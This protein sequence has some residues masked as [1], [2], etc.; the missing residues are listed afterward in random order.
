MTGQSIVSG[1]I[2]AYAGGT[3]QA[4]FLPQGGGSPTV[5]QNATSISSSGTFSF[6]CW[7]NTNAL[8]FPSLTN[9]QIQVGEHTYYGTS[10]QV[11][12]STEDISTAFA[13]APVPNQSIGGVAITN[14]P[15][16]SGKVLTS[17]STT[18]AAWS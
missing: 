10:I 16:A 9:F 3:I 15:S 5:R 8:Y 11:A 14:T 6:Q 17:T 1:T 7:D 4:T 18:A 12:G 2:P 13:S